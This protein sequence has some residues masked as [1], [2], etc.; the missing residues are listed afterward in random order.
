MRGELELTLK[1][2]G[3]LVGR[4]HVPSFPHLL[5]LSLNESS[6]LTGSSFRPVWEEAVPEEGQ[7]GFVSRLRKRAE[8]LNEP[9]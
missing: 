3:E 5:E 6:L 2:V 8:G 4:V 7:L 1:D 9:P